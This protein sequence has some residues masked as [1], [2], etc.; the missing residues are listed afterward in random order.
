MTNAYYRIGIIMMML[1][2][3]ITAVQLVRAKTQEHEVCGCDTCCEE[4]Y[5][6]IRTANPQFN[7]P[8]ID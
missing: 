6:N 1:L 5:N 3:T 2:W 8:A 7:L 4:H